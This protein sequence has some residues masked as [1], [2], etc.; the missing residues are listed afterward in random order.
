MKQ[1]KTPALGPT[2]EGR[3]LRPPVRLA[4]ISFSHTHGRHPCGVLPSASPSSSRLAT[5]SCLFL[6]YLS[7][8]L[9]FP[10]SFLGL[11]NILHSSLFLKI[12]MRL[13]LP[14]IMRLSL[15]SARGPVILRGAPGSKGQKETSPRWG[16]GGHPW[17]T[18]RETGQMGGAF[19]LM[20]PSLKGHS[21]VS[22]FLRNKHGVE[23]RQNKA[24]QCQLRS[25]WKNS[26]PLHGEKT[27]TGWPTFS[28][29]L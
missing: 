13:Q 6:V 19:Q 4:H 16:S 15:L 9:S 8:P 10:Q 28:K 27:K 26:T 2:G 12:E 1:Q 14:G 18:H 29:H 7:L 24:R 5:A 11:K 20:K 21:Q 3:G 25:G 22:W 17:S 23:I